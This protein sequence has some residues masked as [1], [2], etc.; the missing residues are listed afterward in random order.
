MNMS[1]FQPQ[2]K[3]LSNIQQKNAWEESINRIPGT[4]SATNQPLLDV[5]ALT[6]KKSLCNVMVGICQNLPSNVQ[7]RNCMDTIHV[8]KSFYEAKSY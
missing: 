3:F 5:R 7:E 6:Q 4:K 2:V 8:E 1:S